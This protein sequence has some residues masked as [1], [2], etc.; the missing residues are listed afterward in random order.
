MQNMVLPMVKG[1]LSKASALKFRYDAI[2]KAC[3]EMREESKICG[4]ETRLYLP[5]LYFSEVGIASK[6]LELREKNK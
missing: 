5:S 3:I 4:E 1:C 6:I 2:S